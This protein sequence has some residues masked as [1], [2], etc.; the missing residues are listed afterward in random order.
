MLT[1]ITT[2]FDE[3]SQRESRVLIS[4]AGLSAPPV[5]D[6]ATVFT[7]GRAG[8]TTILS[9]SNPNSE[10]VTV[11]LVFRDADGSEVSDRIERQIASNGSTAW[12]LDE[13]QASGPGSVELSANAPLA[14]I[15]TR[16]T[17]NDRNEKI[18][19]ATPAHF[20]VLPGAI[21]VLAPAAVARQG[22]A[23]RLFHR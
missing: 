10:P 13:L 6:R 20:K 11:S 17:T 15:A 19:T 18:V 5:T 1:H 7:D 14:L 12:P 2:L 4:E 16:E 9:L 23:L 22:V 21:T 3:L 8:R